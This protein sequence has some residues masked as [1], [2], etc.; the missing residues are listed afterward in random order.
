MAI[1]NYTELQAA[2]KSWLHRADLDNL[3]PDFITLAEVRIYNGDDGIG[4]DPLRVT[5]MKSQD[6]GTTASQLI[7]FPTGYLQTIRLA[8]VTGGQNYEMEYVTPDKF[9]QYENQAGTPYFYTVLTGSIKVAP[10]TDMSYIHDYYKKF[11]S[12]SADNAT[13][14]LLTNAP[15][16]Y[17][18][19]AL[20]EAM[21]YIN[22]DAR[23]TLWA[24]AFRGAISGLNKADKQIYQATTLQVR[25]E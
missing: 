10:S 1:T 24:T 22:N 21:P 9:S 13:N 23:T 7:S 15:N 17:L 4:S 5:A 18:Y 14:W 19:G 20:L 12:L 11:D 25:A 3:I 8:G 16:A 6:A 2:V